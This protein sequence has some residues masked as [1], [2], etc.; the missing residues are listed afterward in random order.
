M[1]SVPE[2]LDAFHALGGRS[3]QA[4]VSRLLE[5]RSRDDLASALGI[6]PE[7]ADVLLFRALHELDAALR[8][9]AHLPPP[10]EPLPDPEERAAAWALASAL[11]RGDESARGPLLERRYALCRA[12]LS[13]AP[14]LKPS[15]VPAPSPPPTPRERAL[16]TAR[17]LLWLAIVVAA[18]V[19]YSRWSS[20]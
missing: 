19:L 6:S 2:I 3:R 4:L 9:P 17:R 1:P 18:A 14:E 13:A 5:G 16:E 8:S 20:R 12:I 11:A 7:A 10:A 15:L